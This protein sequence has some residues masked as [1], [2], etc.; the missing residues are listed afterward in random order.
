MSS[1]SKSALVSPGDDLAEAERTLAG[2]YVERERESERESRERGRARA[3][4]QRV[5]Q[6]SKRAHPKFRL[7]PVVAKESKV[8]SHTAEVMTH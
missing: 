2:T 1:C 3:K 7:D 8:L 4:R 5:R 6:W